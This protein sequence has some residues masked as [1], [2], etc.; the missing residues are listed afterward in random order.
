MNN[1]RMSFRVGRS[2][3]IEDRRAIDAMS[4]SVIIPTL[5]EESLIA[6]AVS[7][8]RVAG[9]DEIIVVDGESEDRTR[10]TAAA[11][12]QVL[13]APR[14]R[15]TQLQHGAEASSGEVL[16]FLHADCWLEPGTGA[17]IRDAVSSGCVAGC[18]QQRIE[19]TGFAYRWLE[20]GNAARVRA[21]RWAY[22]DQGIFVVRSV[23]DEIGGIPRIP[24]MEDLFLMKRLKCCGRVA[25]LDGPIHVSPRRWESRGIFRQTVQNWWLLLQAHCG[26]SPDRLAKQYSGK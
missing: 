15:G 20:W 23:F 6:D 2:A 3:R 19:S 16:L 8:A 26:V 1:R 12:D 11:A 4:I 14:G 18:F 7:R 13:L 5:N 21:L 24:L 17:A 9:F 25:L 22:G 10:E